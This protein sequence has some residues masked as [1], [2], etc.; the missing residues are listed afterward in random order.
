MLSEPVLCLLPGLLC[1]AVVWEPQRLALSAQAEV[2]VANL[3]GPDT[4]EAM[5]VKVLDET[6]GPMSVAGHSMGA[7][8][9]M[10]MW[11]LAPDRV[12][13]LALF[14]TG[15]HA[16]RRDE[17]PSR[18]ALV[19]MAY[20]QGMAAVA[21]AWLP[22]M[23]HP[24]RLQD[25]ELMATLTAMVCRSSPEAFEAQQH[26]GLHR[27][28]ATGYLPRIACPTLVLCGLQDGWSPAAQHEEM[29]RSIKGAEL[30]L[31]DHCGHMSTLERPAEVI[32]A[33]KRWLG[34]RPPG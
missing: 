27:P 10:E 17:A 12:I 24:D 5:A 15:F 7:R 16:P 29:A 11:R 19:R 31:I 6:S 22:P 18:N 32:S 1:D 26:A 33:M 3:W 23:V 21:A 20:E 25:S 9:A 14:N 4:F 13:R 2:H 28:D 34:R 8:V 30:S